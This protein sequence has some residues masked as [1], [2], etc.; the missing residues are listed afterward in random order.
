MSIFNGDQYVAILHI[1][2]KYCM[3][4]IR[5]EIISQLKEGAQTKLNVQLF[6]HN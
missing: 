6:H 2:H 4:T 1:A 5:A 3:K